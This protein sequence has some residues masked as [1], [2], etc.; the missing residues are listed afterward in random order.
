MTTTAD[1]WQ[2]LCDAFATF[3][4]HVDQIGTVNI[5]ANSTRAEAKEVAQRYF[6]QG[7]ASLQNLGLDDE[8]SVLDKG[9]ES[10]I[11][12]SSGKNAASSYKKQ[13]RSIRKLLP[14]VTTRIELNQSVNKTPLNTS[15]EDERVIET[16]EGL[17]PS[18][19]L[20]YKQAIIDLADEN[21][22][23]FRGPAL[24]L[25]E[26]LR[27]TLDHLAPDTDVTSAPDYAEEKGRHGPTMKQKVRFILKARGQSK[28]SSEVPEQTANTVDE[29]VA[30]ID[31]EDDNSNEQPQI[32]L[33]E[34]LG[35]RQLKNSLLNVEKLLA[36]SPWE[37][38]GNEFCSEN[39]DAI[40]IYSE[41]IKEA[42]RRRWFAYN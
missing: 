1:E 28:S 4:R 41:L 16:L 38:R 5:N 26:A 11:Q 12:L 29:M 17:V 31:D 37:W 6:R 25:R 27:E 23:S 7:R 39:V 3:G 34:L 18:A 13:I 40:Q 36:S 30:I 33:L 14:K 19:A 32:A 21:R 22:L 10:F 35:D 8:L 15:A 9:F 2:A 24:E 20:S 42:H